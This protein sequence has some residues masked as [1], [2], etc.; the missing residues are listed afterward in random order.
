MLQT[1]VTLTLIFDSC[2]SGAITRVPQPR[3]NQ[4]WAA[5][6]PRDAA[7]SVTPPALEDGG[8]LVLA[9]AQDDVT[10][11][12]SPRDNT[13]TLPHAVVTSALPSG[14]SPTAPSEPAT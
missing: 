4:R 10:A 3:Y 13:D 11:A 14:L 6:D 8:A 12:E 9:A 2:H 7:D 5:L 1:G